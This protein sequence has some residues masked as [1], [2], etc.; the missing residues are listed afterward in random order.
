MAVGGKD[1][2]FLLFSTTF[3]LSVD[4]GRYPKGNDLFLGVLIFY[5]RRSGKERECVSL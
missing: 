5:K 2:Q 4:T 3:L 1:N